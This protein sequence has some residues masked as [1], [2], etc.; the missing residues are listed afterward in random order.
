[1]ITDWKHRDRLT[2][3]RDGE[4]LEVFNWCSLMQH[5]IIHPATQETRPPDIERGDGGTTPKYVTEWLADR[6]WHE[7]DV[8][9]QDYGIETIDIESDEVTVL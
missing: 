5:H 1:M 9:V 6:L 7:Y 4:E 2:V 3:M 8:H